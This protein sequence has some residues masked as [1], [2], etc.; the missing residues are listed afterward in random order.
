MGPNALSEQVYFVN[1][2]DNT[3]HAQVL[4]LP[5]VPADSDGIAAGT[6]ELGD[7]L[8]G[9]GS[10]GSVVDNHLSAAKPR[11][12]SQRQFFSCRSPQHA[13][14]ARTGSRTLQPAFPSASAMAL[15]MPRD[16]PVTRATGASGPAE[17]GPGQANARGSARADSRR[18]HPKHASLPYWAKAHPRAPRAATTLLGPAAVTTRRAP[19]ESL[20]CAARRSWAA[21]SPPTRERESGARAAGRRARAGASGRWVPP[22]R[23]WGAE[24]AFAGQAHPGRRRRGTGGP[25]RRGPPG[26][27]RR[28]RQGRA[29]LLGES[30]G[31][32]TRAERGRGRSG[33][34]L[35]V[36]ETPEPPP[37]CRRFAPPPGARGTRLEAQE[38]LHHSRRV[39]C[40]REALRLGS[41][42]CATTPPVEWPWPVRAACSLQGGSRTRTRR[43]QCRP[44]RCWA[45]PQG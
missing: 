12:V 25:R 16:A 35:R 38:A 37:N 26:R 11:C 21:A 10:A 42:E 40:R 13:L 30:V 22:P 7:D 9:A 4:H 18:T 43:L 1:P 17:R 15:P 24:A 41:P 36:R 5:D 34:T 45:D 32:S 44:R 28:R 27:R 33:E 6:L 31:E 19:L 14:C 2:A 29:W 20:A 39:C 3:K 8:L 23:C